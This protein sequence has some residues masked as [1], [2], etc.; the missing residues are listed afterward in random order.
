[1]NK[2]MASVLLLGSLAM[3]ATGCSYASATAVGQDKVVVLRNDGF[4]FGLLREA[5]VCKATE[6]GLTACTSTDSP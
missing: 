5:F 4:L 6:T 3:G 2:L 1:M